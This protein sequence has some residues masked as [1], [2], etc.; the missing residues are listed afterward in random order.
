MKGTVWFVVFF[1]LI[2]KLEVQK[3]ETR[4]DFTLSNPG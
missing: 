1:F 2:G 3:M 4:M